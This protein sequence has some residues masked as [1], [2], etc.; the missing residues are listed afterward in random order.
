MHTHSS[1]TCHASILRLSSAQHR[2]REMGYHTRIFTEMT[3]RKLDRDE[4]RALLVIIF[5]KKA[6]LSAPDMH[7]EWNQFYEFMIDL[8]ETEGKHWKA[9]TR[10]VERWVDLRK[11]HRAYRTSGGLLTDMLSPFRSFGWAGRAPRKQ[12]AYAVAEI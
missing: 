7:T 2:S 9:R 8:N 3:K 11:M 1:L 5:G 6:M 10:R 4:L 12:A